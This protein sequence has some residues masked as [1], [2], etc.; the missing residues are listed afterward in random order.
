MASD[1]NDRTQSDLE[2]LLFAAWAD[3]L[4]QLRAQMNSSEPMIRESSKET[5][6]KE[7]ELR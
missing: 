6:G 1:A 3:Q 2:E 5:I 7:R 4:A